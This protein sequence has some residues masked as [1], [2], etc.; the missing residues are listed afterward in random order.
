MDPR[1]EYNY[2]IFILALHSKWG[3]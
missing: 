1:E 3:S 2:A